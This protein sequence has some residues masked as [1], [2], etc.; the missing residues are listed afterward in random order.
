MP[1]PPNLQRR[2][3]L[4]QLRISR[5]GGASGEHRRFV[6]LFP[7]W[8][9]PNRAGSSTSA[10]SSGHAGLA[11]GAGGWTSTAGQKAS[12]RLQLVPADRHS[13]RARE[14]RWSGRLQQ[15]R[16]VALWIP[17]DHGKF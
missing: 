6:V 8:P 1:P 9:L 10:I 7:V 4:L 16:E 14:V 15:R 5:R 12:E 11:E 2:G 17:A 3:E 13:G